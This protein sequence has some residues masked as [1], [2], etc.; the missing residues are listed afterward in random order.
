MSFQ[1]IFSEW[2][3]RPKLVDLLGS[4]LIGTLVNAPLSVYTEGIRIL[5][6][7]TVNP[8]KGTGIVTCVPSDSPDDYATILDLAKKADYYGIKKEWAEKEILPIIDTP[9]GDLIAKALYEKLKI[10]SPKD[11]KQLAEAKETAY[12]SGFYQG[13]MKY[14]PFAGKPVQD[15]KPLVAKGLIDSGDAFKYAEPDGIVTSRSGDDCVAAYLD[16]WYFCYGTAENGGDGEW[17]QTV[18]DYVDKDLDCFYPEA[19][20]AFKQ[21]IGWLSQWACSRSYGLGTKLPWDPAQ[22]VESL[23]DSTIYMA[24]YTVCHYLHSDIFG[25]NPGISKKPIS[26]KQ[27]TDD[28]WDYIFFRKENVQTDIDAEDLSAMRREFSYWYPFDIRVSGKDL[29]NNHLAFALYH[30]TAIFP[31]NLWP[32]G[33]RVNGHLMLNG[34]KMSKSTGNFLT[35]RQ[36][37]EKFGADA[38]RIAFADGGDGI[39]DP[40]LE[41]Y[42]A[43]AAIL[44]LY[45]LKRWMKDTMEGAS[46]LRKGEYLF[47]D[48]L[49]ENDLNA[50]VIETRR[51]YENTMYKLALKTGF[52]DLQTARDW[53]REQCRAAGVSVHVDLVRRFVELQTLLITP[54]APHWADSV[55][56]EILHKDST[57]QNALYPEAATPDPNLTAAYEYVKSAASSV[58]Q[59]EAQQIK[60]LAKGKNISYDPRKEKKLIIFVADAYPAWQ[61][62]LRNLLSEQF[63][64][65]GIV[66]AFHSN[67]EEAD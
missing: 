52:F 41:E 34:K 39:E 12:K 60:K 40:N 33:Y 51:H 4:D 55:W 59:A 45:E 42:L 22:L 29:V 31:K 44:R 2:G 38:T 17:C 28:V 67:L 15:A 50:L 47:F 65:T 24:Y 7:E 6:M 13:V 21:T 16:Q 46:S 58:T 19:K 62:K 54:I 14:G 49:F 11:T 66:Y 27:M 10:N 1:N 9:M 26:P 43:N 63:H 23:S 35:L 8:S 61:T 48:K 3:T 20:H 5:P 57:V 36:A 25:K 18:L 37:I 53:Y 56:Q 32:Q 64:S 30:H